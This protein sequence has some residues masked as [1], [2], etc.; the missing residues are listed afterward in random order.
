METYDRFMEHVCETEAPRAILRPESFVSFPVPLH[1]IL[2]VK[3]FPS[4]Y[5]TT[6]SV[7]SSLYI[8]I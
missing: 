5:L 1:Y 2:S 7:S 4:N 6:A 8:F 3:C